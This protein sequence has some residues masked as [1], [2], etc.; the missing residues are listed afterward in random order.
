VFDGRLNESRWNNGWW[1]LKW[2]ARRMCSYAQRNRLQGVIAPMARSD[3]DFD[4]ASTP[5]VTQQDFP[6]T[7][8]F[9]S[10]VMSAQTLESLCQ[11]AGHTSVSDCIACDCHRQLTTCNLY[12]ST[13]AGSK[14][15][16][17]MRL[18]S[19]VDWP[20]VIALL[21][22]APG[23]MGKRELDVAPLL[24]YYQPLTEWLTKE[25]ARNQEHIGWDG[26]GTP[27]E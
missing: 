4:A 1:Q 6:A 18:G 16:L 24:R 7:R 19:S 10:D 13:S 25:N 26:P 27:F 5:L 17:A 8:Q 15:Q 9:F 3:D 20:D 21:T 12:G 11:A 22:G 23:Q 14:L 2:V